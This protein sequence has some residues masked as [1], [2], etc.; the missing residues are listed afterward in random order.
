MTSICN[1]AFFSRRESF[2]CTQVRLSSPLIPQLADSNFRIIA[3]NEP[4]SF[5]SLQAGHIWCRS[6]A[7]RRFQ[8]WLDESELWPLLLADGSV[9]I[10]QPAMFAE[11]PPQVTSLIL[12]R[13]NDA[14]TDLRR[15]NLT[16]VDSRGTPSPADVLSRTWPAATTTSSRLSGNNENNEFFP[17]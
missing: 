5:W 1:S 4:L 17:A 8:G 14:N 3:S 6:S 9:R 2:R 15:P 7:L 11:S 12:R 10:G 13:E 16:V